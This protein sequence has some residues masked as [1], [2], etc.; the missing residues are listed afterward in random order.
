MEVKGW[1]K[2]FWASI[3]KKEAGIAI[4]IPDKVKAKID[5]LRRDREGNY[6]LI[7]GS[8]DNEEISVV[9]TYASNDTAFKFLKKKLAKLKEE[10]DN[11]TILV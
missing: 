3:E 5:L 4:M 1:N 11:K 10:V 7:K 6:I 2:I 8:I 9:N